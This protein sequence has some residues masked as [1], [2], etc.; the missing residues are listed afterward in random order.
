MKNDFISKVFINLFIGLL[1]TF[2]AGYI[3]STN[4]QATLFF[5]SG[6]MPWILAI[7]EIIIA[8]ILPV[9]I[10]KMS[11]TTA[12]ILYFLYAA[13]TG[14]T[15]SSIFI[16]FEI[17]SI[18]WIFLI[19]AI[20]FGIFA[21]IGK[22]TKIDL[23]RFGIYLFMGLIG[24]L[25]LSLINVFIYNNTLNMVGCAIGIIVFLGYVAYDMQKI[26]R[27]NYYNLSEDNMATIG[28][29]NLYLDFINI[30]L[31]LLRLFGKVNDN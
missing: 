20:L 22:T 19:T 27:L 28:A 14:L 29:F 12:K 10:Q 8:I 30:F 31:D 23:S 17:S 18:I 11:G 2:L 1:V 3:I 9:R 4:V 25:I 5:C 13:L 26:Y 16:V 21:L 6:S 24:I 7:I 15:F